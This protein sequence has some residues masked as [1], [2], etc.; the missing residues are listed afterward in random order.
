VSA[1]GG[2]VDY[3]TDPASWTGTRGLFRLIGNQL[4]VSG[5]AMAAAILVAVPA[6]V[7]VGHHRRGVVATTSVVNIGR[8]LPA[9]AVL[10]LAFSV[11]SQWGRGLSIWPTAVALTLLAIPP[12]FT[13][14]VAGVRGVDPDVREAAESVGLRPRAVAWRVEAP[15]ALP[16]ILNGVRVSTAQVVATATL[17]AWVGFRCVGSLI[18]E[19]FAQRD[20]ARILT[21]AVVVTLLTVGVDALL[22]VVTRRSATWARPPHLGGGAR[23][24]RAANPRRGEPSVP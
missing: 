6:G 14:T 17:G 1:V 16:L 8:A 3:L 18:F 10:V 2:M 12:L 20:D 21:G 15:L 19:G 11:F 24:R 7:V 5:I 13:S 23:P 9:F 22:G 4:A